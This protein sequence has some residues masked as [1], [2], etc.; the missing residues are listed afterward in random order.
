MQLSPSSC[1]PTFCILFLPS[2]LHLPV[3]LLSPSFCYPTFSSL[4]LLYFFCSPVTMLSPASC[5]HTFSV[6]HSTLSQ[7]TLILYCIL[8]QNRRTFRTFLVS[9]QRVKFLNWLVEGILSH[10]SPNIFFNL[11]SVYY[12]HSQVS[13][14]CDILNRS[15]VHPRFVATQPHTC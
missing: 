8:R 11:I 2:S 14:Y 5:Y 6:L 12:S 13:E 7:S 1:Y 10:S 15:H 4:L 3:T 9:K